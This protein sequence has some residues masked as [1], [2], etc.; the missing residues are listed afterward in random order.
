MK[1]VLFTGSGAA[2]VTPMHRD[3]SINF[4]ALKQLLDVQIENGTNAV[5]ICGTTGEAP[6]LSD[7]EHLEAVGFAV[8]CAAHRVPVIA[9]TGSNDTRHAI[10]M[11]RRARAL[12]ADGLLVVTP[13]YNKTSQTGLLR[14]FTA[15]ADAA[16]LPMIVY[17][18]PART[19]V[20]IEPET[21]LALSRHPLIVAAK[22]ASGDVVAAART[23]ALCGDALTLYSG[24]DDCIV[25]MLS[26]GAKGVISVLANLAPRAVRAL[27]DAYFA[28]DVRE[29]LRLQLFYLP[30]IRALFSDVSPVPVKT[31]LE[32]TGFPAGP[33]R[34]P[35]APMA[36]D[37]RRALAE[38][39][40]ACGIPV[41][42]E[43][44]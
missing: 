40:T 3:G 13:Y 15:I 19:G 27:C 23:A 33:C 2:L 31:A 36:E 32:M 34:L 17:N 12:G 29:S 4:S 16:G 9:G 39:M 21:Y 28:G 38:Q 14:H 44:V 24:N 42:K 7:E 30:L 10:A 35:L 25:P 5:I 37:K 22:E 43:A 1:Q 26:L 41:C 18:V 11:S 6:T 20:N 8:E